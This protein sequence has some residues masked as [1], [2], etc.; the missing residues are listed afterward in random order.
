[1][2]Q[3]TFWAA[4]LVFLFSGCGQRPEEMEEK[5]SAADHALRGFS[6]RNTTFDET[7]PARAVGLVSFPG[8]LCTGTPIQRD[9]IL[10]AGHCICGSETAPL[11]SATF[12]MQFRDAAGVTQLSIIPTMDFPFRFKTR[13]PGNVTE[14]SYAAEDTMIM[15]LRRPLT[16]Q[17]LPVVPAVYTAADFLDRLRNSF[18]IFGENVPFLQQ[19][20]EVTGFGSTFPVK[21]TA[22]P[23]DGLHFTNKRVFDG[24]PL[25]S[26]DGIGWWIHDGIDTVIPAGRTVLDAGDSGGP[27]TVRIG[28]QTT[29]IGTSSVGSDFLLFALNSWTPTWENGRGNGKFITQFINDADGDQVSDTLDNCPPSRCVSPER[30]RNP[31]QEDGDGDGAG[32]ACDNCSGLGNASQR[33]LDSDRIGDACDPCPERITSSSTF[34]TDSDGEPNE[35]D[36]CTAIANARL[37]CQSDA[38]CPSARCILEGTP[39]GRCADGRSCGGSVGCAVGGCQGVGTFGVCSRQVNDADGDGLGNACDRCATTSDSNLQL[40]SNAVAESRQSVAVLNDACDPVPHYSSRPIMEG[41]N[42]GAASTRTL[43][44]AFAG[45]GRSAENAGASS[46]TGSRVG[47]RHCNCLD[48]VAGGARDFNSCMQSEC[49]SDPHA[50]RRIR[51][52]LGAGDARGDGA[53]QPVHAAHRVR[54]A[55]SD[56]QPHYPIGQIN[57][58]DPFPHQFLNTPN[59]GGRCRLG[60]GQVL[61]WFHQVDIDAGRVPFRDFASRPFPIPRFHRS[62]SR[63]RPVSS[64]VTA[65]V[66]RRSRRRASETARRRETCATT[67]RT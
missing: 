58:S 7:L 60:A 27:L 38:A 67:T 50:V 37:A 49:S 62:S 1:M 4:G 26:L 32:D 6:A 2:R 15:R 64:G 23:Q 39:R 30:C 25:Y 42:S 19:P 17:E 56:A 29:I 46:F 35:C 52:F 28:G 51:N 45:V 22:N 10:T 59:D 20:F 36:S 57:C 65:S 61:H 47:F 13:C 41:A 33:D 16:L 44:S 18:P 40:N 21:R 5:T 8:G 12:Q 31:G 54:H 34:D 11:N 43:F 48:F 53:E 55:E 3:F 63:R 24:I 9:I 66:A 14:P